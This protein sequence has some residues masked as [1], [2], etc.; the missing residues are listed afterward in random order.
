M[1]FRVIYFLFGSLK[2]VFILTATLFT[3]AFYSWGGRWRG[4]FESLVESLFVQPVV[5]L[6]LAQ[7]KALHKWA[8]WEALRRPD[9]ILD[10]PHYHSVGFY[11]TITFL[12]LLSSASLIYQFGYLCYTGTLYSTW[13][14]NIYDLLSYWAEGGWRK[15][16]P[17]IETS[18]KGVYLGI[19]CCRH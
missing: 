9:L 10:Q 8:F 14:K 13:D 1:I 4:N 6:S 2:N 7:F 16:P 12:I 3:T 11:H 5:T 18:I 15:V 17:L 19:R